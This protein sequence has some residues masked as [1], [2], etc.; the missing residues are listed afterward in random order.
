MMTIFKSGN[1][2]A[3]KPYIG[4]EL[5]GR[6]HSARHICALLPD[7]AYYLTFF[8]RDVKNFKKNEERQHFY[9]SQE[10]LIYLGESM[11]C[12]SILKEMPQEWDPFYQLSELFFQLT[13][14]DLDT[15][16]HFEN[17]ISEL[18]TGLLETQ[19]PVEGAVSR[20]IEMRREL[21]KIKRYYEQLQTI[22]DRLAENENG[23]IPKESSHRFDV[24]SKRIESLKKFVLD[25]R[26]LLTQTREAYQSKIDIEQNQI[27]KVFTVLTAVFLPLTLIVGWFGMNVKMPEYGWTYGYPYVIV[28]SITVC[29]ICGWIFKK[30]KWF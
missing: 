18:E 15:L 5:Q 17:S 21:L 6:I 22:I 20:I 8:W 13:S 3:L 11:R 28:L 14:D 23:I 2:E 9:C 4:E 26:E 16:Q 24:L 25:L 12:I 29:G 10:R 30:K 7:N 1:P 27:M 19:K